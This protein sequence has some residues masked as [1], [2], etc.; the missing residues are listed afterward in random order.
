MNAHIKYL[1]TFYGK[2]VAKYQKEAK[3]ERGLW[4]DDR[5][6]VVNIYHM[7][8][9]AYRELE[10]VESSS[11]KVAFDKY[12]EDRQKEMDEIIRRFE[13]ND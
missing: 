1:E 2:I 13:K 3:D 10:T 7:L 11:I 9:E 12:A 5:G 8:L 4:K 6:L